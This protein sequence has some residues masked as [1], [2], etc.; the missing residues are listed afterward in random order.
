MNY[1]VAPFW[2]YSAKL[3]F[4]IAIGIG[5]VFFSITSFIL[6]LITIGIGWAVLVSLKIHGMKEKGLILKNRDLSNWVVYIYG[7]PV[8]E[9]RKSLSN[10][11]FALL[12]NA[13]KFLRNAFI[14]KSVIQILFCGYILKQ[15]VAIDNIYGQLIGLVAGLYIV[16]SAWQSI[17]A[18]FIIQN[19]RI[20]VEELVSPSDSRWYQISFPRKNNQT[21]PALDKLFEF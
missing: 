17:Y 3:A 13:K 18:I 10:P 2:I 7:I 11:C 9:Q 16:I 19:N 6:Y 4:F 12:Q 8:Q 20:I 14:I 21:N 1:Q 15:I 5:L